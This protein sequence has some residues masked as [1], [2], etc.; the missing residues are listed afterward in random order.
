MVSSP[1]AQRVTLNRVLTSDL[2]APAVFLHLTPHTPIP[3]LQEDEVA[4]AHWI[5]LE[6][7][8]D[9][10][11]E[12]GSVAVDISQRLA[13]KSKFAQSIL[14]VLVGSMYFRCIM[15]PNEP[16][17]VDPGLLPP[18]EAVG[19]GGDPL[20]LWGLTLGSEWN[21]LG[22]LGGVPMCADEMISLLQ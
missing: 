8:E 4:S 15:L 3:E 10:G 2:P 6:Q 11:A 1:P 22:W 9:P 16:I 18:K 17:M 7:L 21:D 12:Y 13:P 19:S 5:P 14:R 20:K